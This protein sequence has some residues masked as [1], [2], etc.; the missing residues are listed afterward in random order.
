MTPHKITIILGTSRAENQSQHIAN[1]LLAILKNKEIECTLLDLRGADFP[2][3][4]ER[5]SEDNA[6]TDLLSDWTQIIQNS[7]GLIIV[8]PEYKS[9]YPGSLKNF[10]DYLPAGVFRYKP[11][12]IATISSGEYAGTSCMAQLRQVV[13]AMGG[14]VIP[15]RFQVG[16]VQKSLNQS[17]EIY[18]EKRLKASH[19]FVSELVKYASALSP[20]Q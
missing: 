16:S 6:I 10:L 3:L 4:V 18:L 15:D 9:G 7:N 11:V 13:I 1:H 2:V 8:S 14:L 12:G 19:K 20:L 5:V 17:Q